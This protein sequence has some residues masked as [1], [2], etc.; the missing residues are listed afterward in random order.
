MAMARTPLLK[1]V[2]T[3]D[4]LVI[5]LSRESLLAVVEACNRR[6]TRINRKDPRENWPLYKVTDSKAFLRFLLKRL[7]EG[8]ESIGNE[9]PV[10]MGWAIDEALEAAPKGKAG[11]S[12][13]RK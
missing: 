7:M 5:E 11:I 4:K 3:G 13:L 2:V 6:A 9:L 1:T 8:E 10:V 12:E